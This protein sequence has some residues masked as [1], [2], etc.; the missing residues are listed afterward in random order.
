MRRGR[1]STIKL[2]GA[3]PERA[4]IG[5]MGERLAKVFGSHGRLSL[6]TWLRLQVTL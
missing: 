1:P 2:N 6:P 4:K 5:E 3:M